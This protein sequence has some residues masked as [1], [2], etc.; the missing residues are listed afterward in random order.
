MSFEDLESILVEILFS[1][2]LT[3]YFWTSAYVHPL[4]FSFDDFFARF[5]LSN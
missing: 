3:L 1:F 2:H 5:S 4:S